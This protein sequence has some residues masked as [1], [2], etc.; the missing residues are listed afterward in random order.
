MSTALGQIRLDKLGHDAAIAFNE[1]A[2]L[3]EV[4]VR[5][6]RAL[7]ALYCVGKRR[8]ISELPP[9]KQQQIREAYRDTSWSSDYGIEL[10][11]I[12]TS[13][14]LAEEACR[15][16]GPNWFYTKLPIDS[17]LPDEIVF[18]EWAHQFPGSPAVREIH[19]NL[20]SATVAVRVSHL[21]AIEDEVERL[22]QQVNDLTNRT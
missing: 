11:G 22:K 5:E 7:G 9:E 8:P 13:E 21:R 4:L 17:C 14:A 16:R 1:S 10:Q 12:Y 19:E 20:A 2:L 15:D 6:I 18:G 3:R